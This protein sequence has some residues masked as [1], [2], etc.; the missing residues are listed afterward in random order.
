MSF[1]CFSLPSDCSVVFKAFDVAAGFEAVLDGDELDF[2]GGFFVDF[3]FFVHLW[4]EFGVY[5]LMDVPI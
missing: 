1:V 4:N 2:H 5:R 3:L